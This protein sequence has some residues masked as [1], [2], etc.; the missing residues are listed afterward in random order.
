MDNA[1]ITIGKFN[2]GS[3]YN[4]IPGEALM[5]G[6]VRYYQPETGRHIGQS[7]Q[8]IV[9]ASAAAFGAEAGLNYTGL[10]GP[11]I[12]DIKCSEVVR[13]AVGAIGKTDEIISL[14]KLT[15][16]EDFGEYLRLVPGAFV[17]LGT[18]NPAKHTDHPHHHENFDIDEDALATGTALFAAIATEFLNS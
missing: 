6:T 15:A 4:I 3:A 13:K 9:K 5:E 11:V 12:N 8:R 2:A 17:F 1:V 7:L 14:G 18:G 16:G 10:N